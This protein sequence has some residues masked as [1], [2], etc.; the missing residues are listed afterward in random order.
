[1]ARDLGV[2]ISSNLNSS[3]HCY[4]LVGCYYKAKKML[5]LVK[6]TVKHKILDL[7]V[8]LYESLV[9][10]HLEYCSPVWN[11]HYVKDKLLL[12]KV[13]RR[14]TRLFDD[15]KK[16]EYNKRLR[17]LKLWRLEER[18]NCAD[19][20]ELLKMVRG[21]STVPPD[22]Y[23]RF[24]EETRTRGHRY[25]LAKVHSRCDARLYFFSVRVVCE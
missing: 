8:R 25:K 19:L 22:S 24:A 12:D 5:G 20:N 14:F 9:R 11:P 10:S 13:Q 1:M 7:M 21:I 16:L 18:R 15:L 17:K 6:R 23:F 4:E 2:Y 3:E